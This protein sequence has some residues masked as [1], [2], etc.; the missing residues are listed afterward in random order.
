MLSNKTIPCFIIILVFWYAELSAQQAVTVSGGNF[1]GTQGVV[2]YSV[3]QVFYETIA[4]SAGSIIQGVQQPYEIYVE[5]GI[6]E[7]Q[8]ISVVFSAYPNPAR[9]FITLAV[10]NFNLENLAFSLYDIN[11]ILL[12]NGNILGTETIIATGNLVPSTYFLRINDSRKE[13][14]VFKIIKN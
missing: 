12:L 9:D 2:S 11:G 6:E 14:K 13:V 3:G 5:T 4:G 1:S 8:G 7:T 10:E